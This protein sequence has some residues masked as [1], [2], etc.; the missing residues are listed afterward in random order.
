MGTDNSRDYSG[1]PDSF[2]KLFGNDNPEEAARKAF[3]KKKTLKLIGYW[4]EKTF[5]NE[6]SKYPDPNLIAFQCVNWE[7]DDKN[8]VCQYLK[9]GNTLFRYRGFSLC[10]ICE[11]FNGSTELT[12]G[13]WVWPQGLAHYVEAHDIL[14]PEDFIDHV[15]SNNGNVPK[16]DIDSKDYV[17]S[18][19]FWLEWA[20]EQAGAGHVR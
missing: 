5:R 11:Q 7:D 15:Y 9:D 20:E 13:V 18:D 14:L 19:D 12:D 4:K 8:R 16:M 6:V 3:T 1:D 17:V 2:K 10:R